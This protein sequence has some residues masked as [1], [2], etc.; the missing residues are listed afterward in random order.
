MPP[1]LPGDGAKTADEH[2]GVAHFGNRN[3]E[4]VGSFRVLS[5]GPDLHA[6]GGAVD[7]DHADRNRKKRQ[8]DNEV[9]PEQ[10]FSDPGD[11]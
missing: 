4:T 2:G 9:L 6:E 1:A 11:V 8:I 3:A 7:D 5:N 10:H